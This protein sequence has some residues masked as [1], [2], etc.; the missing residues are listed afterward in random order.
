MSAVDEAVAALTARVG[1]EGPVQHG[2][3]TRLEIERYA[4][5]SGETSPVY[6]D[7]D[8]AR[9]AGYDGIPAPPVM[10]GS[11]REWGAGPAFG[12]LRED[13]TGVGHE[14]WL[15][16]GGLRLMGGGQDLE[17][18]APVLAGTSFTLRTALE[19]V[20]RKEGGSGPMVLLVIR[21]DVAAP[22]GAP[23]LTS[24]ETLI[25]R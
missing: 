16:L 14:A 13:G 5:A 2:T 24:R 6:F 20:E 22:D 17:L 23:L 18:H 4:R 8:A 1:D 15:P 11:V 21:T 19:S 10:L 12:D 7:E 25:G 9:A 3:V